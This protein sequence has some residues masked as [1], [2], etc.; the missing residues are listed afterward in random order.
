L[1]IHGHPPP[2][3]TVA[4]L[5]FSAGSV[6]LTPDLAVLPQDEHTANDMHG[7]QSGFQAAAPMM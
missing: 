2:A 3:A 6:H 1:G 7:S 4:T 5:F